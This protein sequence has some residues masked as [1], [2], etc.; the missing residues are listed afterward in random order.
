MRK[1]ANPDRDNDLRQ[2]YDLSKLSG[3]VRGKYYKAAKAGS[4]VVLI[5]A[6]LMEIFRNP[7]AVN[8]ALRILAEA[9]R[10]STGTAPSGTATS[11]GRRSK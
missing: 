9:A 11:T 3:G 10:A 2:E 4:N 8:R 1:R 6:D 5:D 7:E